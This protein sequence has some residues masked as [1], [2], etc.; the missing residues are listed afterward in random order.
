MD[1]VVDMPV[2]VQRHMPGG[3]ECENCAGP[4]VAVSDKVVDVPVLGVQVSHRA[5]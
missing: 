3:S 5:V 4:E 1:T 2:G